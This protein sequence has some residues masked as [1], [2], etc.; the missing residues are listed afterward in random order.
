[1]CIAPTCNI[2][3]RNVVDTAFEC[4]TVSIVGAGNKKNL[5]AECDKEEM[6]PVTMI[7]TVMYECVC[8]Y[9]IYVTQDRDWS[10]SFDYLEP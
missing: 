2:G 10:H 1:M 8:V 3:L 5:V 4:C 6:P 9:C 7:L